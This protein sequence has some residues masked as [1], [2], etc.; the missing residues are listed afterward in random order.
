MKCAE[1]LAG[2]IFARASFEQDGASRTCRTEGEY[3]QKRDQSPEGK[4]TFGAPYLCLTA[5]PAEPDLRSS[6]SGASLIAFGPFELKV[7]GNGTPSAPRSSHP[8]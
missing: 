6:G 3:R 1:G 8:G 7:F 5:L 4:R 2:V